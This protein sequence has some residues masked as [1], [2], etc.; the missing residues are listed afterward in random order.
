MDMSLQRFDVV[1]VQIFMFAHS[2]DHLVEWL[3]QTI[4]K[5]VNINKY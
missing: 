2:E 1:S 3:I 5:G 4:R